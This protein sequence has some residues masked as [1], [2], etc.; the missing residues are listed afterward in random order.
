[1]GNHFGISGSKWDQGDLNYDGKVD[2]QDFI[3]FS[4]NMGLGVTGGNGAG[5]FVLELALQRDGGQLGIF[6]H[7]DRCV[8]LDD[9]HA[10]RACVRGFGSGAGGGVS[11][12]AR[13]PAEQRGVPAAAGG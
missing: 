2:F 10:A 6:R 1:M 12:A 8:G 4:N 11:T 7:T 13:N 5:A 9:R 3:I